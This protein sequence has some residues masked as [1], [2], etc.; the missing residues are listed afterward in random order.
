MENATTYSIMNL[1]PLAFFILKLAIA[2]ASYKLSK[3]KGRNVIL[4]TALGLIPV[5]NFASILFLIGASDLALDRKVK[6]Y[7][8]ADRRNQC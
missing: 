8:E 5:V 3:R 2:V 1:L 6:T 4:W 7:I